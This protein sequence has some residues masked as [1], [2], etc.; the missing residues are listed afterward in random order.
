MQHFDWDDIRYFLEVVNAGTLAR[1]AEKLEVNQS[2][3]SRR[4]SGLEKH[5]GAGLF[6]R[7]AGSGWVL[8]T[9]GEEILKSAEH[10]HDDAQRISRKVLKNSTELSGMIKVTTGDAGTHSMIIATIANFSQLYPQ[11]ELSI[12]I[13]ND[14]L[15]LAAREADVAIRVTD[16]PPANVVGKRICTLGMAIY[17]NAELAARVAAGDRSVPTIVWTG[18]AIDAPEWL[19]ESFPESQIT[20][21]CN[22]VAAK[23]DAAAHGMGV[24]LL[25]VVLANKAPGLERICAGPAGVG[26]GLWILSHIDLRSTARVR[27]FRDYLVEKFSAQAHLITG[28]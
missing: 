16:N 13:S 26:P 2:T 19:H 3:V 5:L 11:I 10:M 7:S 14:T 27:V 24:T 20:H 9:A 25:P 12:N 18:E 21:R 6:D 1:A 8:S 23:I 15:D 28:E 22:T 17:G 4:I